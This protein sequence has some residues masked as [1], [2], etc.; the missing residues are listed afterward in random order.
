MDPTHKREVIVVFH[1]MFDSMY[2]S[3]KYYSS[4]LKGKSNKR[5]VLFQYPGQAYTI[6]QRD[7]AYTNE[8]LSNFVD[9]FFYHLETKSYI[10]FVADRI[11]FI[12]IGYG[13]NILLYYS[14]QL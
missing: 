14:S 4:T 10:D 13:G 12:G 9:S 2:D 8:F 3:F 7:V 11:K 5:V 1:D 6:Y